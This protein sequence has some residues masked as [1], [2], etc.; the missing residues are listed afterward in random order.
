MADAKPFHEI[1]KQ[2]KERAN[3]GNGVR[4]ELPKPSS[5]DLKD[6]YIQWNWHSPASTDWSVVATY[7]R[8]DQTYQIDILLQSHD[9]TMILDS[10][11]AKSLGEALLAASSWEN[12]WQQHAGEFLA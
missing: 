12:V 7:S 4:G 10:N 8:T 11:E 9:S 2:I 3:T 5:Q 6:D 1:L